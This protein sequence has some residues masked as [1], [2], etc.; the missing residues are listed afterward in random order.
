MSEAEILALYNEPHKDFTSTLSVSD[1]IGFTLDLVFGTASN[2]TDGYDPDYDQYAPPPPP[3][4]VFDARLRNN[5]EDYLKDYRATI[6]DSIIWQVLYSPS[7]GG[8][9]VT[10]SWDNTYFPEGSFRLKDIP[11]NGGLVNVDMKSLN[12]FTDSLSLHNLKIVYSI[13]ETSLAMDIVAPWSLLGLPLDVN[14]SHYLSL[15]PNALENTLFAYDSTYFLEDSLIPGNGYWLRFPAADTVSITGF[16]INSLSLDLSQGWH[17]ISGVSCDVSLADIL[18][19][20][21]IIIPGTIYGWDGAYFLA[22]SLKPGKGYWMQTSAAGQITLN[23]SGG[24]QQ[25]AKRWK[26]LLDLSEYPTL[27]IADASGAEQFLYFNVPIGDE[28]AKLNYSMPPLPPAGAFDV[29]IEGNYRISENEEA[30]ILVQ[31]SQYPVTINASNLQ[32]NDGYEYAI[33]EIVAGTPGKSY[34][35]K[36]AAN[37]EISNPKVKILKLTN[38]ESIPLTFE[39]TQN[40]PNPF[41]PS[42]TIKYA[43]PED[44]KVTILIYNTLGQKVKKLVS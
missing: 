25:L 28:K 10:L 4:G 30:T 23:C 26:Q 27:K 31:T 38:T 17:L 32:V 33:T 11:T 20:S 12:S 6:T 44:S 21:G 41:N 1:N 43:I 19:P 9:P 3:G 35:L 2:A 24:G 18:D 37:I 15:F 34:R 42:T 7:A 16:P 13:L 14:N 39:V 29:R 8:E 5:N 36:N 40:Y 22:D